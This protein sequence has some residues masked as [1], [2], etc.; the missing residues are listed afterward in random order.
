MLKFKSFGSGSSGNC[1]YLSNGEDA[2]LI[3]AG[4]GIR[5]LKRYFKE[6]PQRIISVFMIYDLTIYEFMI[7]LSSA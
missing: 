6:A 4:V 7:E 3:D 5:A 1:Y 2:L